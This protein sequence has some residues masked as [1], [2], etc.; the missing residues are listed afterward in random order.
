MQGRRE[1]L[2]QVA[3]LDEM[4]RWLEQRRARTDGLAVARRRAAEGVD[5]QKEQMQAQIERVL[6]LS[7]ALVA[8]HRQVQVPDRFSLLSTRDRSKQ[9][10]Y[11]GCC[12]PARGE[13]GEMGSVVLT[14]LRQKRDV[15]AAIRDTLDKV[16]VLRF[17]RA[18]LLAS[19]TL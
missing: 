14:T 2:R 19:T 16:L 6:P 4:R 15:D 1:S 13:S 9:V 12:S 5:R 18:S 8:V 7:R 3:T 11:C 17:G 10:G